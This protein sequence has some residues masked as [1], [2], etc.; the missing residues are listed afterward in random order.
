MNPMSSTLLIFLITILLASVK[1]DSEVTESSDIKQSSAQAVAPTQFQI[2]TSPHPFSR[3]IAAPSRIH[4]RS[5]TPV[6]IR[7]HRVYH[8]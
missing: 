2:A 6:P 7:A 8:H 1:A 4:R 3:Q 5:I